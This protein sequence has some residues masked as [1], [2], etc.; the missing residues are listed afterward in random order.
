[1]LGKLKI[2]LIINI[3][4]TIVIFSAFAGSNGSVVK[5]YETI[6]ISAHNPVQYVNRFG[7]DE[8][9]LQGTFTSPE[10]KEFKLLGFFD[11]DGNGGR[12][13]T[14]WKIRFMP[15]ELGTWSYVYQWSDGQKGG[16]GTFLVTAPAKLKNHGNV[17]VDSKNP[18]CLVHADGSPHY[19]WGANWIGAEFCLGIRDKQID[20]IDNDR[21]QRFVEY[22][23]I[24]EKFEHNGILL[25]TALFPLEDDKYSWD[26]EWAHCAEFVI[27]EAAK[28]GIYVQVNIFD[29]WSRERGEMTYTT[30]GAKH[31][32]NVWS[33]GDENAKKNYIKTIIAR[34]SGF[35]NVYW[36][37]GNEM[38]RRPNRG[39][40][41]AMQ[42]NEKYIPWIRKYDPY[43]LPIG[44]SEDIYKKCDV[45]IGFIHQPTA[46]T[47]GADKA[48]R[49]S[50]V[51]D[52][53]G[54]VIPESENAN[55]RPTIMNELVD[56]GITGKL[57]RDATIREHS[58]RIAYRRAFWM[59]FASGGSG[60]SEATW[61]DFSTPLNSAV[62]DVM[63]DQQ[64]LRTFMESLP[65]NYNEMKPHPSFVDYGPGTYKTR[66]KENYVYVTYFLLEPEQKA[67][68]GTVKVNLPVGEYVFVWYNPR[69]G[70]YSAPD[71]VESDGK[72]LILTH[73]EFKEDIVLKITKGG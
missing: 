66:S 29:T 55:N 53:V 38:E 35:Y 21:I 72:G 17:R 2:Y 8:I 58:N 50:N 67:S 1:M 43:R 32:F 20:I 23:D 70:Q 27:R 16:S 51:V 41:F 15:N 9:A 7:Y 69:T 5:L 57:W 52:E 54:S 33:D 42:A 31:V 14:V 61:L 11:G 34:F 12:K 44:L 40:S 62:I 19:W 26:L 47:M 56:G 28:R 10:N 30:D 63:S 22:L 18:E 37:L 59:M 49:L 64:R 46:I 4:F 3:L 60:A 25:K 48:S 24:L 73:S 45:D 65:V 68:I 36:E 39:D 71:V 13:G 6:E